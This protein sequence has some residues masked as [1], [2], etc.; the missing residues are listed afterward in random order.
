[1][2][3]L[4]AALFE[5]V[6]INLLDNAY[7]ATPPGGE[8]LLNACREGDRAIFVVQDWGHGIPKQDLDYVFEPFYMADKA[9]SRSQ[10]GSGLGLTLCHAIV[11]AHDGEIRIESEENLGT[12]VSVVL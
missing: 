12:K 11:Q 2:W 7:K 10:P 6:L 8:I 9:R 4:D 1:V 5:N 3:K